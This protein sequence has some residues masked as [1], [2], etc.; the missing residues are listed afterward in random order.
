ME[1]LLLCRSYSSQTH[2]KNH[3]SIS[4]I[5]AFFRLVKESMSQVSWD[6]ELFKTPGVRNRMLRPI[7]I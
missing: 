1:G 3:C 4:P 6:Q 7:A 2:F 5:S